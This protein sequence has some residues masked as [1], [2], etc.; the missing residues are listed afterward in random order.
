MPQL[1]I[2]L[3]E[4]E[5]AQLLE[6]AALLRRTPEVL[7]HRA[8][9]GLLQDDREKLALVEEGIRS[10]EEEG[11]IEHEEAMRTLRATIR[12]AKARMA[13]E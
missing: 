1:T 9:R 10:G 13:A 7:G 3:T 6:L 8:I 11:W 4:Y 2:E 12:R 5:H